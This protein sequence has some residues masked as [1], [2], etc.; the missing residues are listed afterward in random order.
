[1]SVVEES[2]AI[3]VWMIYVRQQKEFKLYEKN[4]MLDRGEHR[5]MITEIQNRVLTVL[6]VP[7]GSSTV[8]NL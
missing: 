2:S 7:W 6:G 1:M 4:L 5:R 3:Y 8:E